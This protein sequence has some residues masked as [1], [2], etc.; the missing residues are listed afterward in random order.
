MGMT[1][2]ERAEVERS[3][4]NRALRWSDPTEKD[5][6]PDLEASP[7]GPEVEGWLIR[8]LA[9]SARLVE[10]AWSSAH[11]H[12][13]GRLLPRSERRSSS[14]GW[15]AVF[16][17]EAKALRALRRR[18]EEETAARLCDIDDRLAELAAGAPEREG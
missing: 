4:R 13:F 3:R 15:R 9:G 1:K 18:I 11:T 12:G 5:L 8:G 2:A 17:T 10:R 7:S 16:S 14:Q 6:Q